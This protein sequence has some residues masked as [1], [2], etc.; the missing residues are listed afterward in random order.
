M[1]AAQQLYEESIARTVFR[2][3]CVERLTSTDR[4]AVLEC[5]QEHGVCLECRAEQREVEDGEAPLVGEV[6]D[7]PRVRFVVWAPALVEVVL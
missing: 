6:V 4:R 5:A 2:C 3:P 7:L 1:S